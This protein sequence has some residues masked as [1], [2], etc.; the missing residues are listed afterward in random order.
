MV[1]AALTK[2]LSKHHLTS[3]DRALFDKVCAIY[4]KSCENTTHP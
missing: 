2:P 3:F 1:T 4:A